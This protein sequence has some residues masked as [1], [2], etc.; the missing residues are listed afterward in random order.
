MTK[1]RTEQERR[2]RRHLADIASAF[3]ERLLPWPTE[4]GKPAFLAPGSEGGYLSRLAD[5]V[6]AVQLGMGTEVLN[7]AAWVLNDP[8]A[9]GSEL[10]YVGARLSECLTDALRVA[11]SRGRRLSVL[12]DS[13]SS[14]QSPAEAS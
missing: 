7:H 10:R 11:E 9:S 14:A 12:D 4:E 3:P 8:N 5:E 2:R 13:E 6:E 1:R